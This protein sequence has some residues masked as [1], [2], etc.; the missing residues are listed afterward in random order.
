MT[1]TRTSEFIFLTFSFSVYYRQ[2][3]ITHGK[4]QPY[5]DM[6]KGAQRNLSFTSCHRQW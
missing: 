1:N 6:L 5:F 2:V 3:F 4:F